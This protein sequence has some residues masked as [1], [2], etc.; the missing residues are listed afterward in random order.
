M[1]IKFLL[2]PF[3]V[4]FLAFPAHASQDIEIEEIIG[5]DIYLLSTGERV[6][7]AGV[8][9]DKITDPEHLGSEF[10]AE[11][12]TYIADILSDSQIEIMEY[13]LPKRGVI[14]N[15]FEK[16]PEEFTYILRL[17]KAQYLGEEPPP[18]AE[19]KKLRHV[20][21]YLIEA[22]KKLDI[23]TSHLLTEDI[24]ILLNLEIIRRG[25]AAVDPRYQGKYLES[26]KSAEYQAKERK[27]GVWRV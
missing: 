3:L 23:E 1:R 9:T 22:K 19:S 27:I 11:A 24:R 5:G 10:T 14:K 25:Y 13:S 17:F 26:F 8:N 16:F 15:F 4:L 12:L 18:R 6:V 20:Y 21:I 7:L 2:I